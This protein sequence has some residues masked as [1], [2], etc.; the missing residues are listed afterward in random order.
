MGHQLFP[1]A[2]LLL[3]CAALAARAGPLPSAGRPTSTA[4]ASPGTVLL[5]T[6]PQEAL[7]V[8][9]AAGPRRIWLILLSQEELK[10]KF[11]LT[12]SGERRFLAR[13]GHAAAIQL[14]NGTVYALNPRTHSFAEY[15]P[16]TRRFFE[17]E[18]VTVEGVGA[19][20][21]EALEDAFRSAVRRVVGVTVDAETL[22]KNGDLVT[23]R[24]HTRSNGFI[25]K[26]EELARSERRGI[27]H[28]TITAT[29]R[30][31]QPGSRVQE[32]EEHPSAS[33][34]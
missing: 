22:V 16:A 5:V 2:S 33:D 12:E 15:D 13:D 18:Q 28:V 9:S 20:P 23:D 27:F 19:T 26:Y 14:G 21:E 30:E 34:R 29:V 25:I 11:S 17:A 6:T 8:R 1:V 10:C 7:L 24:V 32:D 3:A 4:Q 31:V